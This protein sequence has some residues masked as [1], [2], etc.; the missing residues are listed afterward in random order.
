MAYLALR[1]SGQVSGVSKLHGQVSREIFQPLFPR[2]PQ[3]DVPIGY[4]TNGIHVPTW[5]SVEADAVWTKTCGADR[6]RGDQP[7][8]DELRKLT[9]IQLGPRFAVAMRA[10]LR[11]GA[12]SR[13]MLPPSSRRTYSPSDSR[14]G[15]PPISAPISCC[16]ILN[17][18][19]G[20]SPIR[21]A[22]CN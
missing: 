4:V 12:A 10:S 11:L 14:D 20:C 21:S 16:T 2:W 9:D 8:A 13:S 15:L 7:D 19:F 18:W 1:G 22:L 3:K 17:D 5:D 6:W